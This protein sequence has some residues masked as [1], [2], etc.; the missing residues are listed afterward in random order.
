[1]ERA[2]SLCGALL[3][4]GHQIYSS[5]PCFALNA[6]CPDDEDFID[7]LSSQET[8]QNAF[9]RIQV[10]APYFQLTAVN[11][12]RFD[13]RYEGVISLSEI[14]SVNS[15]IS[16]YR[17]LMRFFQIAFGVTFSVLHKKLTQILQGQEQERDLGLYEGGFSDWIEKR[18]GVIHGDGRDSKLYE[19][20]VPR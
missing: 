1:M 17:E 4:S 10:L 6:E 7:C 8:L 13:D 9:N 16:K 14:L 3:N 15:S 2:A 19:R 5:M 12:A 18:G 20:D 11:L